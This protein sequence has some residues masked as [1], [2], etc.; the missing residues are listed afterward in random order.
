M[1][2]ALSLGVL[3]H[4]DHGKTALVRAL[5]GI[6]TDRLKEERERGLS[7]VLG[8]AY[9]ETE[10]GAV[11]LIDVPGHEDFIRAMIGGAAALDG[12]VLCVAANE[13]LMPQTVEHFNI[14]RLLGVEK[15][16][17][18]I[19]KPDLANGE[20]LAAV[21]DG[22]EHWV[23]GSFLEGAPVLEASPA[24]GAGIEAVR[25]AAADLAARPMEREA[26][27]SFFLPLDRAF[28]IRGFGL[29]VTGTLRGGE[30]RV[31]DAVEILPVERASTVRGLQN[32][33]R[34]IGRALPGQR[35]A[36][37]LRR[38]SRDEVSRG[39]VLA[40]PGS[41]RPARR[42]D[43]EIRL[44]EDCAQTLKNGAVVRFLTGTTEAMARLRL[45]DRREL[46]PGETGLAQLNL[47]RAIATRPAERF[48]IRSG[49]PMQTI[50]G[51]RILDV[52]T[53]RHRR[54]DASVKARLETAASGDLLRI[55]RQRL[56]EAGGAG[57]SLDALAAHAGEI[58]AALGAIR[59]SENL[60][61][62]PEALAALK[63]EIINVLEDLHAK[64]PLRKGLDA[65][66][67]A[68]TL[69]SKSSPGVLRHALK[70]LV[71]ERKIESADELFRLAGYD[72]FARLGE[73][74]RRILGEIE[75]AFLA[76]GLEPPAPQ[77]VVGADQVKQGIYRLLLETGRLVRLKTYDRHVQIVLH[78]DTLADVERAIARRF[79][80][81]ASFAVKDV[82]DLLHSTR[83]YVVP[84]MEHLDA[85][86]RT[87]RSG[88]LRRLRAP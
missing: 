43:T 8:F 57:A 10:H 38:V 88:D 63:A 73:R 60:A 44:L 4:V 19:T 18:V 48:L 35:V 59:V 29:V 69:R 49:S 55:V 21:K 37:N 47:D 71:E 11:D 62:A 46:L 28:T 79:P 14:A 3:G 65:G 40:A 66:S 13:G 58:L 78:A 82:R 9:F 83:R 61:V 74:E 17:V 31:G 22:L 12:I 54:F 67:L 16:F 26:G 39:E 27:G 24:S 30:L 86:G 75:K 45:L 41:V 2:G 81:P 25:R 42:I 23:R 20:Q 72:P 36:V 87:A 7:M 80:Y 85:I 33:N 56:D 1:S 84:V 5:T 50:G 15:G 52:N 68:S 77:A 51:G 64:Y 32:H 70:Q 76:A 6:E 53:T 34:P